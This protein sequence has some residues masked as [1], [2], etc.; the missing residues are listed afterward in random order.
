MSLEI[1]ERLGAPDYGQRKGTTGIV[2]HTT[3]GGTGKAGAIATAEWQATSGNT[4]GGSYHFIV[5]VDGDVV[6]AVKT[7]KLGRIAGSISTRRDSIWIADTNDELKGALGEAT[8]A[9]PNSYLVAISVAGHTADFEKNGWPKPLVNGLARLVRRIE[10]HYDA[11]F[12]LARHLQFQSNRSDPGES[13]KPLLLEAY[14]RIFDPA[15][16]DATPDYETLYQDATDE[17]KGL[18]AKLALARK[19]R[20]QYHKEL[21]EARAKIAE[22]Q[23]ALE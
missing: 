18:E 14:H 21:T 1:I 10:R 16:A 20:D 2:L 23:A 12:Y 6:T 11:D 4:S 5:G 19:R 15:P 22:A 13:L 3:E 17:I 8:V 9:D 7:V